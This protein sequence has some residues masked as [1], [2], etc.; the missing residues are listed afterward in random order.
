MGITDWLTDSLLLT[1]SL[2]HQNRTSVWSV[3]GDE[4]TKLT[5]KTESEAE[6]EA[7]ALSNSH[8]SQISGQ[9]DNE[10]SHTPYTQ[11]NTA[12][13]SESNTESGNSAMGQ[14][15]SPAF[16]SNAEN[17]IQNE[18]ILEKDVIQN[19]ENE[20]RE[21]I[22]ISAA[23]DGLSEI[24][25]IYRQDD[26]QAVKALAGGHSKSST[27]PLYCLPQKKKRAENKNIQ[28]QE[29]IQSKDI[30]E[31]STNKELL[32]ST[33][34]ASTPVE[35]VD[36]STNTEDEMLHVSVVQDLLQDFL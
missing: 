36:V 23:I 4:L 30:I 26:I 14:I 7:E 25:Q 27:N 17:V 21:R 1:L 3:S 34:C 31:V 32:N 20:S 18:V 10:L 6:A 16:L 35:K 13:V 19:V 29:T 15:F 33:S 24:E 2:T 11:I 9:T 12:T 28:S 8:T 22:A 5:A